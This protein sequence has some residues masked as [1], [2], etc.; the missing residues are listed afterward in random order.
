MQRALAGVTWC[1]VGAHW[2]SVEAV[3][4]WNHWLDGTE[5]TNGEG[6]G[7]AKYEAGPDQ[8]IKWGGEGEGFLGG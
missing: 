4:Q 1:D 6:G 2:G 8:R 5:R 7:E 3:V